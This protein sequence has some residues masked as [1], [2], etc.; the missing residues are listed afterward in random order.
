METAGFFV[1]I[2]LG[3]TEIA[4]LIQRVVRGDFPAGNLFERIEVGSFGEHD[5]LAVLK[6]VRIS[7]AGVEK[8]VGI[9]HLNNGAGADPF[10]LRRTILRHQDWIVVFGIGEKIGCGGQIDRMTIGIAALLQIINIVDAVF[11]I[12][13]AVADKGLDHTVFFRKEINLVIGSRC[14]CGGQKKGQ[15]KSG[16]PEMTFFNHG[17]PPCRNRETFTPKIIP[18]TVHM[19]IQ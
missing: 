11:V 15:R 2:P 9:I 17:E 14:G 10:V 3:I 12:R 13:H 8:V 4:L 6:R 18:E 16:E 5:G 1:K 19:S 7:V